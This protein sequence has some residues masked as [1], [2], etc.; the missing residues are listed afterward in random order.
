LNI[1]RRA[2][3]TT[4]FRKMNAFAAPEHEARPGK[5][6]QAYGVSV[7]L[8]VY[9]YICV[10]VCMFDFWKGLLFECRCRHVRFGVCLY[11]ASYV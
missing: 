5:V 3:G 11:V 1:G 7:Y 2:D 9:I 8:Y 6:G 10:C 4:V